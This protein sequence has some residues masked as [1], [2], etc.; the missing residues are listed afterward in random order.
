[1]SEHVTSKPSVQKYWMF[2]IIDT[3]A[4]IPTKFCKTIKTIKYTSWWSKY[5]SSQCKMMD[6]C[7]FEKQLNGISPQPLDWFGW[8]LTVIHISHLENRKNHEA[9][10]WPI[11][12]L[13]VYRSRYEALP[14]IGSAIFAGHTV[15]RSNNATEKGIYMHVA[16]QTTVMGWAATCDEQTDRHRAIAYTA[17]A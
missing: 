17:R 2:P 5:S 11:P 12:T 3:S 4:W 7:H 9:T 15:K 1:M 16:L 6:S 10:V 8:H 14:S 13:S